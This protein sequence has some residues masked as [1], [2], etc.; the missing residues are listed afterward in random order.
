[1]NSKVLAA[2]LFAVTFSACH[3]G[4]EEAEETVERN[5]KYKSESYRVDRENS[6]KLPDDAAAGFRIGMPSVMPNETQE[7]DTVVTGADT[8]TIER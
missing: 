5:K 7:V 4:Q 3:Y 1:M 8:L 2:A 6:T